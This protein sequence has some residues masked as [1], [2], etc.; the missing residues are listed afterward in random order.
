MSRMR[1]CPIYNRSVLIL[2]SSFTMTTFP[3]E[4][5]EI[6][7]YEA[8]HSEMPSYVRKRLMT[9]CPRINRTWKAVYASIASRDMYITNFAFLGYLC[10][11]ARLQKSIIYHDFI[12]RLTRTITCFV[13][14]RE[15]DREAAKEV[16][17]FL[18][19]LPNMRDFDALFPHVPYIFFELVW[20]GI[21]PYPPFQFIRGILICVRYD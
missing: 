1:H 15:N 7:V 5:V 4:L 13:N 19:A 11:I 14:L 9:A 12:P 20:S 10:R 21:G 18:T 8:W 6:I 3:P 17:S 2:S 16:Y